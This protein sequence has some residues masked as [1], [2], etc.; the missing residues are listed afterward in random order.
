MKETE[1]LSITTNTVKE[2]ERPSITTN[3]VKEIQWPITTR[4]VTETCDQALITFT[5]TVTETQ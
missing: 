5:D 4:I 2:T 1:R 3:T